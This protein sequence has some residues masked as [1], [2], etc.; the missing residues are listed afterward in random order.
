VVWRAQRGHAGAQLIERD[1]LFL[2]GLDQA[3]D[4]GVGAGEVALERLAALGRGVLGAQRLQPA[5][6]LAAHERG[7]SSRRRT[8]SQTSASRLSARTGRLVHTRPPT[9]RQPSWPMQR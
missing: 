9:C 8:A 5:V 7:I 1:E 4:R 2:V 3:G 6:D